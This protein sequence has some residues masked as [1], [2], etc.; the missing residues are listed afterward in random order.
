MDQHRRLG[1]GDLSHLRLHTGTRARAARERLEAQLAREQAL[2]VRNPVGER[3][4]LEP[5]LQRGE[6]PLVLHGAGL[7]VERAPPHGLDRP[8]LIGR[9]GQQHGGHVRV[10]RARMRQQFDAVDAA[11]VQRGDQTVHGLGVERRARRGLLVRDDHREVVLAEERRQRTRRRIVTV[12]DQHG[13]RGAGH[14]GPGG[15]RAAGPRAQRAGRA[16]SA[17]SAPSM[18]G[19]LL[20]SPMSSLTSFQSTRPSLPIR[21]LERQA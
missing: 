17:A 5:A 2:H 4:M 8:R 7:H 15:V 10:T 19:S 20:L 14:R 13:G 9:V 16:C 11:V 6:Q 12:G 21:K 1:R 3:A 18:L